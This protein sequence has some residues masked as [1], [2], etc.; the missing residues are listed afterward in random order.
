MSRFKERAQRTNASTNTISGSVN[1]QRERPG[2]T[3]GGIG[4]LLMQAPIS[5]SERVRTAAV[6]C[7]WQTATRALAISARSEHGAASASTLLGAVKVGRVEPAVT[8]W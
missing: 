5:S 2:D 8:G 3:G 1:L 6:A 7:G 4:E